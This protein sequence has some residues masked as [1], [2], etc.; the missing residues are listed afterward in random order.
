MGTALECSSPRSLPLLASRHGTRR[1][2]VLSVEQE[3]RTADEAD[4]EV[5]EQEHR[6]V[7]L[8]RVFGGRL[9]GAFEDTESQGRRGERVGARPTGKRA[10]GVRNEKSELKKSLTRDCVFALKCASL[11]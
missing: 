7:R 11:I 9:H 10:E 2:Q 4:E 3:D 1:S 8:G 6:A 5:E